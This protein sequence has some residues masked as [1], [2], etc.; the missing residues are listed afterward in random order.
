VE[1]EGLRAAPAKLTANDL[2]TS[3]VER[4]FASSTVIRALGGS[5]EG[6]ATT[7]WENFLWRP[8]EPEESRNAQLLIIGAIFPGSPAGLLFHRH[9]A[10]FDDL[11]DIVFDSEPYREAAVAAV[12]LRYLG[13]PPTP[14]EQ[15]AFTASLDPEA[16]DV[17]GVIE[18]VV[19]SREYFDQ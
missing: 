13:R 11:I 14:V 6:V 4:L 9:G 16:P 8:P 15:A 10:T 1:R 18:S 5:P 7:I 19:S 17:R 3:G 12:F 2:T